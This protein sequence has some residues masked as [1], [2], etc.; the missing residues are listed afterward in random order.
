M[1]SHGHW[2]GL[3]RRNRGAFDGANWK[4]IHVCRRRGVRPAKCSP[5]RRSSGRLS[6]ATAATVLV[7]HTSHDSIVLSSLLLRC[8]WLPDRLDQAPACLNVLDFKDAA[9]ARLMLFNDTAHYRL[10]P[11]VPTESLS[12]WWDRPGQEGA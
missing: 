10:R 7:C 1:R 11:R 9:R 12:K 3:T 2:E 6:R 4:K 8:A 5:A